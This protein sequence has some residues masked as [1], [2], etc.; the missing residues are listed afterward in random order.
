MRRPHAGGS[1]EVQVFPLAVVG[2]PTGLAL[3]GGGPGLGVGTDLDTAGA[4]E[5]IDLVG[6]REE[7]DA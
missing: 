3:E 6:T 2:G 4:D 5:A 1:G 7:A